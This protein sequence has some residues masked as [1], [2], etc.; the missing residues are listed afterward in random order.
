MH[1]ILQY[2]TFR[3]TILSTLAGDVKLF[4]FGLA[5]EY[6]PSKA[7]KN[8]CFK[9]TGD[10]GSTR[11]MPPEVYFEKPY[12]QSFDVYSFGILFYQILA[13]ETPFEGYTVKSFPK[14][15]FEK[16][17]RP[18]PDP[19]WPLA[20]SNLMRRCWS[21]K[22]SERPSMEEISEVLF[23]EISSNTDE[24]VIDIMDVSRKSELSLRGG[25]GLKHAPVVAQEVDVLKVTKKF[26]DFHC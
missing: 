23:Q 13:L 2:P 22:I 6:Y 11:Y 26:D 8:G 24:E 21:A 9:M 17:A 16:G 12:N 5:R 19:K 18:V 15:V 25:N 3:T 7:D 10:T 14:M 1:R 20:I 4:D